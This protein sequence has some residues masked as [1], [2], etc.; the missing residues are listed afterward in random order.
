MILDSTYGNP[1]QGQPYVK[2]SDPTVANSGIVYVVSGSASKKVKNH[3]YGL[4]HPIMVPLQQGFGETLNGLD[5]HGSF[6]IDVDG[7]TLDG[8]FV[9]ER[10]LVRDHFQIKKVKDFRR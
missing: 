5:E 3:F 7:H 1:N 9:D 6:Y 8:K 10:G 4:K 2:T